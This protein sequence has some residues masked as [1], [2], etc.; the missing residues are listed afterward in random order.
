MKKYLKN[1]WL[2]IALVLVVFGRGPLWVIVLLAAIGPLVG[3][4]PQSHRS[5]AAVLFHLL[6]SRNMRG[7][8]CVSGAAQAH[9]TEFSTSSVLTTF[10]ITPKLLVRARILRCRC[11]GK[12]VPLHA[13]AHGR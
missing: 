8:R 6:A 5:W 7:H 12:T 11:R 2:K 3:P 9:V 1:I 13:A 10:T 4:K